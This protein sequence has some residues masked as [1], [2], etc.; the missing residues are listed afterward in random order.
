MRVVEQKRVAIPTLVESA[1]RARAIP[2]SIRTIMKEAGL[3][4]TQLASALGV[5][6]RSVLRWERGAHTLSEPIIY[7]VL[8]TW[9]DK[10][11]ST[12]AS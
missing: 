2:D 10:L 4:R 9:A 3:N 6:R 1:V 5:S 11:R 12:S 7:E 8:K